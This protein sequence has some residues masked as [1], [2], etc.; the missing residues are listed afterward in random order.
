MMA[1]PAATTVITAPSAEAVGREAAAR[2][3]GAL[4]AALGTSGR[5]TL[6]L[7]GGSTPRTAYALL[8]DE[9]GIDWAAVDV[10]WV[11]ERAVSPDDERSNYRWAREALLA[12]VPL[13]PQH[14]HRMRAEDGD[15]EA[16]A[17]DYERALRERVE[18][19]G[20]GVPSF[21]AMVLGVGDDGHTA[22]LF[23]GETAVEVR[24][25]LVVAVPARGSREARLTLTPL[26][27]EHASSVFVLATGPAKTRA[28]QRAWA[29]TGSPGETPARLVS[30]CRGAVTWLVD[31]AAAGAQPAR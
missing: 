18:L 5:A 13:L 1:Q 3:A 2:I 23:P 26:V 24:D 15:L 16:R 31:A 7:S 27:I 20:D 12:R 22:S 25:R 6:A 10:F 14:V 28:L 30:R 9:A 11:D 29:E 17:A 19:D 8:A 4:R 21:D